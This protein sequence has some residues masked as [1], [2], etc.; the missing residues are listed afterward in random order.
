LAIRRRFVEERYRLL[1]YLYALAEQNARRGDPIMRPVFYDY[2]AA[3]AAKCDQSMT[4]TVGGRLLVAASPQPQSL[5]PY[6]VCLPA[7]DWFDYWTGQPVLAPK[8]EVEVKPTLDT[9][10]VY[11]RAGTILPRQPLVRSSSDRP[12][13]PLELHIYPGPDCRGELY[14]DDGHSIVSGTNYARQMV[15]C[16]VDG[17]NRM[18]VTFERREGE[19]KPWWRTIS[20]IVHGT[21][22][23]QQ[24]TI[25]SPNGPK[26]FVMQNHSHH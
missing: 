17:N 23:V 10:P 15:G 26:T 5:Q 19:F 1:P 12:L 20:L 18:T 16:A 13:G 24:M 22:S 11:V 21:S 14:D 3:L 2:P 7:G 8:G 4:F 9:L 25:A 6:T